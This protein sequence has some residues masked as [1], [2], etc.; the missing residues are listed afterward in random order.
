MFALFEDCGFRGLESSKWL[1]LIL[2][3]YIICGME[4]LKDP[5]NTR[6]VKDLPPP[7]HRPM[8]SGAIFQQGRIN[9]AGLR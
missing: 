4:L 5:G 9:V 6:V 7:P 8:P 1:F 2:V 3:R